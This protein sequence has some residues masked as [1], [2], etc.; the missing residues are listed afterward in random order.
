MFGILDRNVNRLSFQHDKEYLDKMSYF[1][2]APQIEHSFSFLRFY[3][4]SYLTLKICMGIAYLDLRFGEADINLNALIS[5]KN[6]SLSVPFLYCQCHTS[7]S[8]QINRIE[9]LLLLISSLQDMA[10][11]RSIPKGLRVQSSPIV[12]IV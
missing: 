2:I 1:R 3:V 7:M 8:K 10:D 9:G 12:C 4:K 11:Y 6:N 5:C